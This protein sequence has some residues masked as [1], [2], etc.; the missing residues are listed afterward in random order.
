MDK[1]THHIELTKRFTGGFPFWLVSGSPSRTDYIYSCLDEQVGRVITGRGLPIARGYM[2]RR[3]PNNTRDTN[4]YKIPVALLTTG[5]G[6][7]S[8]EITIMELMEIIAS[9]AAANPKRKTQVV[10]VGTCGSH[11][12]H[13][14]GGDL[15]IANETYAPFG[16]I[17]DMIETSYDDPRHLLNLAALRVAEKGMF[18]ML[19]PIGQNERGRRSP[20]ERLF[21]RVQ[22]KI[23]YELAAREIVSGPSCDPELMETIQSATRRY[24][25]ETNQARDNRE[26]HTGPVFSKLTLFSEATNAFIIDPEG[27]RKDRLDYR[28]KVLHGMGVAASEMEI[29]MISS[30][31]HLVRQEGY[32]VNVGGIMGVLNNPRNAREAE[33]PLFAS[34][35]V[36]HAAEQRAVMVGLET[37]VQAYFS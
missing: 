16:A 20:Q 27:C 5:M 13:I 28:G 33:S 34:E 29:A 19:G 3:N 4:V 26:Y 9:I 15:V 24:W 17:S 8:S 12:P 18:N 37:A 31:A 23:A 21:Q 2:N 6:M 30:I 14:F 1:K 35:V 7:S 11:Q 36:R 25:D 10:R 32:N 22:R